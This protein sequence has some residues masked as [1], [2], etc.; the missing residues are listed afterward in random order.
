VSDAATALGLAP[1]DPDLFAAV[2]VDPRFGRDVNGFKL[3]AGRRLNPERAN[4]AMVGFLTARRRGLHV[5]SSLVI[6]VRT[7]T[8]PRNGGQRSASS[9][10][11]A[12]VRVVG[13]EASSGEFPPQLSGNNLPV[14]LAPAFLNT[15][16]GAQSQ[17]AE[18]STLQ[19]AMRLRRGSRDIPTVEADLQRLAGGALGFETLADSSAN[20]RRSIHLQAV[21]LWLMAGFGG[22]ATALVLSQ[23]LAR[24]GFDDAA[25][26]PTLV[27]LGMTPLQLYASQLLRVAAMAAA[28]A[29]GALIV[30]LLLSPRFPLGAARI[31]EPYPGWRFDT[32]AVALGATAIIIAVCLVGA[33]TSLPALT[34]RA[35]AG[36][37]A[38]SRSRPSTIDRALTV[39]RLPLVITTGIRLALQP[40][41]GQ[42]AVPVRAT[43]AAT[44][45]AVGALTAA[46]SFGASL[47]HLLDSPGLYGVTFDAH[48][49]GTGN[50]SDLTP[51]GPA[52]HADP[53]VSTAAI[54]LVGI[55]FRS[56][57]VTFGAQA[58]S[59]LKGRLEPPV[60]AGRL[61]SA[62]DEILLGSR[63]MRQLHTRVGRTID[64]DLPTGPP[65]R[66]RVVGRGVLPPLT[67]TEQ[68]GR[69]G[70]VAGGFLEA[71]K[72]LAPAMANFRIPPP[73]D[74]FVS[75]AP[76]VP[77]ARGISALQDRLGPAVTVT[78]PPVP[79]DIVNFG[80]VRN[81]PQI[82]AG[83]LGAVAAVTVT[84]LLVIAIRRRRHDLAILKALGL[85]PF[86]VSAAI[87][88][89]ASA[90]IIVSVVIGLP[91]GLAAGR[92][93]WTLVADQLGV[94]V[95]PIVPWPLVLS[96]IPSALLLA[97]LIAAGPALVAGRIRPA[98]VLRSE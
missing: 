25:D 14:Y 7:G 16:L 1:G 88:W 46:V 78:A 42:R 80:Q 61:P 69:G 12:T 32:T 67:D 93:A 9:L 38:S 45:I 3:V 59:A 47:T 55:P 56:G 68:L 8:S 17:H 91:L 77:P 40:G 82:L 92:T 34:R 11:T 27:A 41:Q 79:T 85:V 50:F 65:I 52:L 24:Q 44:A 26:R 72:G 21:A 89:Q 57:G 31:A 63:T 28:G 36:R 35:T 74:G 73:G 2:L 39:A 30:A 29:V 23:L 83:L 49:S 51:V 6:H 53:V 37:G 58:T 15:P 48:I 87:A 97:N 54:A 81:L 90:V 71:L 84:Y 10:G 86:Q 43:L 62:N 94:V 19:L 5:G 66:L 64:V 33:V 18:G 75:F 96:L 76:D 70:V 22:L 60:L 4:E 20:V 98:S 95:K 13:I